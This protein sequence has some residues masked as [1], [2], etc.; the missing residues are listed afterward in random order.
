MIP[1]LLALGLVITAATQ[2]RVGGLPLGPGEGLLLIWLLLAVLR[3][4]VARTL[5]LGPAQVRIVLFWLVM[6]VSLCAGMI[7][8]LVVEPFQYYGGMI[9]DTLAYGLVLS[10]SIMM[11]LSLAD[12]VERRQVCWRMAMLGA[13]SL[14]LQIGDGLGAVPMPGVNPWYWDRFRGW[15][16]N[17]NQ[18]GFFALIITLL[19]LHLAETTRTT[20]KSAL[21]LAAGGLAI[22][23]GLMSKSDSFMIGFALSGALYMTLKSVAWMRDKEMTPTLRGTAVVLG[24][25][26]LPLAIVVSVPFAAEAFARIERNS[27]QIYDDNNQGDVR[28]HLWAEAIDKGL[29]SRLVGFGPGPHLTS[30][31]YKSPPPYKFE[32]HNTVLDLFTQGGIIGVAA[33]VWISASALIGAARAGR[34]ALAG[35]VVGMLV[36]SMFHYVFRHP[37]FWFGIVLCL[38]EAWRPITTDGAVPSAAER[39]RLLFDFW[40]GRSVVRSRVVPGKHARVDGK[41][42]VFPTLW[43]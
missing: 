18:L 24:L 22:A 34:P 37:I 20:Y 23:A 1:T 17:P 32:A 41:L 16:E 39:R 25:L 2:L 38:L 7:V 21:A 33:F 3:Q 30:K 40:Q 15:A 26:A 10:F 5:V 6:I 4:I 29:E 12:P 8:G 31:S 27:N 35:L 13:V 19:N 14:L 43:G 28:L 36:F 11:A 42:R 9:R